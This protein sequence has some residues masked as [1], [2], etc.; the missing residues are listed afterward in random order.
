MAAST[1]FQQRV[2]V[3]VGLIPSGS[4][5]TYGRIARTIGDARGARMVG[6]TLN[7]LTAT[8][9]LPCHRV[10]NRTGELTGGWAFGHP[11]IM[12]QHLLD[13]GIPFRAEYEVDLAACVWDPWQDPAVMAALDELSPDE[14]TLPDIWLGQD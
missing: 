1:A 13:E 6:W 2:K 4:V 8:H 3:I 12:R 5:T 10:V 11:D 7:G 14:R 9:G